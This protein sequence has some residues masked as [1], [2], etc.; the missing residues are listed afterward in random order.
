[1]ASVS[2]AELAGLDS[3]LADERILARRARI[4]RHIEKAEAGHEGESN[5]A[6]DGVDPIPHISNAKIA[7]SLEVINRLRDEATQKVSHVRVTADL[8]ES[9]RRTQ[10][11]KDR[12][13]RRKRIESDRASS[14]ADFQAIASKWDVAL[15]HKGVLDLK[16]ALDSQRISCDELLKRKDSVINSLRTELKRKDDAYVREQRSQQSDVHTIL[17][18]METKGK[19]VWQAYRQQLEDIEQAFLAERAE[20][21]KLTRNRWTNLAYERRSDESTQAAARLQG[22]SD[23]E[24]RMDRLR[25]QDA[26]EYNAVKAKLTND[27]HQLEQQLEQMR[28]TYLLNTEKLDYNYQVLKKRSEENAVTIS[29]Q[30]RK[31][32]R[33]Q[34]S[35]ATLRQKEVK[36][37]KQFQESNA[38]LTEDYRR[39]TD[40]FKELQQKARHFQVADMSQYEEVFAMNEE[41]ATGVLRELL[42][43]DRVLFEQQLGLTWRPPHPDAF[44]SL[45]NEEEQDKVSGDATRPAMD[46]METVLD[47]SAD[48]DPTGAT[49]VADLPVAVVKGAMLQL[50][51]EA[52]YLIEDKLATLL[53]RLEGKERHMMQL[54]SIFKALHVTSERDIHLLAR[55]LVV[56][57]EG[58]APGHSETGADAPV[59]GGAGWRVIH[60]N[61]IS[62]ALRVFVEQHQQGV[63]QSGSKGGAMG[64]DGGFPTP[65]EYREDFWKHLVDV[66]PALH[67]RTWQ[68][69]LDGLKKYR[70]VLID[71]S[72]LLDETDGL[73]AQNAELKMLLQ[74]YLSADV[75]R[76]LVI[77]PSDVLTRHVDSSS[78]A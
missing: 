33:T 68:G 42:E 6:E 26:V 57:A 30:K 5:D 70:E 38:S 56:P 62:D 47:A 77:P 44:R 18:T 17:S 65:R 72:D 3:D 13:E 61:D 78:S 46:V 11:E 50:A 14:S 31:I 43:V 40:R 19:S 34:D 76:E 12:A 49:H 36:Q 28:A 7:E 59:G 67:V 54:D 9:E 63:S 66:L 21:I 51:D 53:E 73:R 10:E 60:P 27:I 29:H 69:L 15:Q 16:D 35:I 24:D 71:R 64:D 1:M 39:L 4:A 37:E 75:N 55:H 41:N 2:P 22:I 45:A 25:E 20:L 8:A 23:H 32:T 52:Q 74:Q 58:E 48:V